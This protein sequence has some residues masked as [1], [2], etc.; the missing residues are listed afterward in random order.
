[1]GQLAGRDGALATS[2]EVKGLEVILLGARESAAAL[3]LLD[4]LGVPNS[5]LRHSYHKR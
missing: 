3:D 1:L 5:V 4:H 2:E